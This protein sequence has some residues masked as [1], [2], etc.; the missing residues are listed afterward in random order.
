[1]T[2]ETGHPIHK[3]LRSSK[4]FPHIWCAGCGIGV[5]MGAMVRA[6][7]ELGYKNA[8]TVVVTGIGCTG[9][10]DDYMA[11]NAL[12]T[13]HGRALAFAT[14][15]KAFNPRLHVAV[16]MGDGDGITIGGNHFLHAARR[17]IDLTA[18]VVNNFNY[19]MTGGQVSGTTPGG[20]V[21]STTAWGN[22]ERDIDICALADVAGANYVARQTPYQGWELKECLKEA[23]AKRGFSVVEV[24]SPCPTHFGKNNDMRQ[25]WDLLRWLAER[26]LPLAEYNRLTPSERE[27][28]FPVG[29]LVD[30]DAPDFNTRYAEVRARAAAAED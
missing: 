19:G 3:Y 9:M 23:L 10:V 26:G 27:G 22:P 12:H 24:M 7:E 29:K 16:L 11:T 6:F 4:K 17:N 30:R 20:R 5:M 14:G 13:T 28:F 18:I 21:T 25:A 2:V 1:V 15:I 8:D